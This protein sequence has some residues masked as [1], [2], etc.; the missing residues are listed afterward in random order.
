[1]GYMMLPSKVSYVKNI[2]SWGW[3]NELST[4]CSVLVPFYFLSWFFP[5]WIVT[6]ISHPLPKHSR[7]HLAYNNHE[8]LS[9][10]ENDSLWSNLQMCFPNQF[11]RWKEW[12]Q[13][14]Q[15][16]TLHSLPGLRGVAQRIIFGLVQSTRLRLLKGK[17]SK[18]RYKH[19]VG[20]AGLYS[21]D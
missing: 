18:A 1:M 19:G 9:K 8:L 6:G 7:L 11:E 16:S 5:L 20:G 2:L 13:P 12:C 10:H 4:V 3:I 14:E 15:I 21:K 17:E